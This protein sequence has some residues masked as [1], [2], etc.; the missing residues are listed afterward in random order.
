MSFCEELFA[1]D[2]ELDVW[3]AGKFL[4][5]ARR[6]SEAKRHGLRGLVA[7][8][9]E[10]THRIAA[11]VLERPRQA[12]RSRFESKPLSPEICVRVPADLVELLA[13]KCVNEWP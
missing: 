1:T 2:R 10:C 7:W 6:H 12:R 11:E 8:E 5:A 9:N 4:F 13:V 3:I